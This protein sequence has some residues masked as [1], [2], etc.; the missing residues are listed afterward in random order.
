MHDAHQEPK[1]VAES[2][3]H[4]D[5]CLNNESS[6][7]N[8]LLRCFGQVLFVVDDISLPRGMSAI[9]TSSRDSCTGI[10]TKCWTS[11]ICGSLSGKNIHMLVYM[12]DV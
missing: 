2:K 1:T 3:L 5:K 9:R 7:V 10:I 11:I 12:M 4:Q 8:S 6:F